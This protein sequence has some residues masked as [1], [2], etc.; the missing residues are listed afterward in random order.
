MEK[1]ES[2]ADIQ[3]GYSARGRLEPMPG[4]VPA[5]QLR[6]IA[7]D[8]GHSGEPVVRF[9]LADIPPRYW[10]RS[11][12][13]LFRSRGDHNTAAVLGKE[14]LEPAVAVMPLVILRACEGVLP[15]YLA[16]YLN[17]PEAQHHF[18]LGARGT[19]IRMI[20]MACLAGLPVPVPDMATQRAISAIEGLAKREF[21]L[22]SRLV[23][24]R[25]RLVAAALLR[26]AHESIHNQS[27]ST[28][29]VASRPAQGGNS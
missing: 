18:D 25:Q 4:G 7:P 21:D 13:V 1:L 10:A 19:S 14:F 23:A 24:Q 11:G 29:A 15:Q 6:D 12:D 26:A 5:V 17:Q 8:G 27:G 28:A 22:A 9:R 16:W 2:I 3:I 20:P